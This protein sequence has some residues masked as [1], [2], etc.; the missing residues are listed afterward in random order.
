VFDGTEY[1]SDGGT[2]ASGS[3]TLTTG[4]NH[5]A[6][7]RSGTTHYLFENGKLGHSFTSSTDLG[8][9]AV[10]LRIGILADNSS[11]PFNGFISNAR[12][13]KG[14]ALY[15]A[16]FTPPSAPLTNVTNTKLLCCQSNT[17]ATAAAVTPGSITANGNAAATNFNPFTTDIDAVRGQES[18]YCTLNPLSLGADSTLSD[19]NLQIAYGGSATRNA[20]MATMGMSSGKWY[21]ENTITAT[22]ITNSTAVFGITNVSSSSAVSNY[23]G[24]AANGWGY[25]GN[26]GLKYNNGTGT[27]FGAVF[28][29]GDVIGCAFD[30]DN[31]KIWWSKNG[32]WQASGDPVTGTNA[33]YSS[34]ASTTYYPAI[35][36][37]GST[38]TF[39]AAANFGQ[40]PFKFPPPE[41]F[42]TLCLANLP[43]PT[44]AT[45]RP[46]K[47]FKT[48]LASGS[49]ILGAAQATFPYGFF[50]IK[51]RVNNNQ[52]QYLDSVRG[53]ST[54]FVT[55]NAATDAA[56]V[57]PSGNSVAW[58][59][60]SNAA[61]YDPET[62]FQMIRYQGNNGNQDISH[63]LGVIP[64]MV[65][66][67][68]EE[69]AK[70]TYVWHKA[71]GATD[72]PVSSGTTQSLIL[73]SSG[74]L[75]STDAFRGQTS[76]VIRVGANS[77]TNTLNENYMMYL[78]K[79][80]PDF[81]KFGGYS[82]GDG[83][84]VYLGF[85]PALLITKGTVGT[86]NWNIHDSTRSTYNVVDDLIH[87]N[88]SNGESV[89]GSS[90]F[91]FVSNGFVQ[92]GGNISGAGELV[93]YAAF[94]ENPFGGSGVNPATA[95]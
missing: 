60:A 48:V 15:T 35:G 37:G 6:W 21:W 82:G 27:S 86:R 1:Y 12:I 88:L 42:K 71:I 76:S 19:G 70:Q 45:L 81:S 94:A 57:A 9:S 85:K 95:R 11:E 67:N 68:A 46:D 50:W 14:T 10:P 31:G 7:V 49:S 2:Y 39:T 22:S 62:G 64:D 24:F 63:D 5:V 36:D 56:Y 77:S 93:I 72:P 87:P 41:G 80:I 66:V 52:H 92:R 26:D 74:G 40:K 61:G 89:S 59:W 25:S 90:S 29:L 58:C 20:T 75:V 43:R 69:A 16:D 13:I 28:G 33:A 18:G 23:P 38:Q 53:G 47:Y 8:T 55:P 83:V 73:N 30:A 91:D 79:S 34:L 51:D 54:A 17:S 3:G 44:K 4:W 32:T 65:W 78:W 84:F